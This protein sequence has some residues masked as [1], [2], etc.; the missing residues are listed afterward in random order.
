MDQQMAAPPVRDVSGFLVSFKERYEADRLDEDD[1]NTAVSLVEY[2]AQKYFN[3]SSSVMSDEEFDWLKEVVEFML[4]GE[5]DQYGAEVPE[6]AVAVPHEFAEMLG[7][8]E[9]KNDHE[10]L[11]SWLKSRAASLKVKRLRVGVSEKDDGNSGAAV[12]E[13]GM[14]E[15]AFT[16]GRGGHGV[17]ITSALAGRVEAPED[18]ELGVVGRYAVQFEFMLTHSGLERMCEEIGK[19]MVSPRSAITG[20]L[21]QSDRHGDAQLRRKYIVP[22]ALGVRVHGARISREK[23]IEYIGRYFNVGRP[24]TDPQFVFCEFEGTPED[25]ADQIMDSVYFPVAEARVDLDYM[26]DGLVV[27][28]LGDKAREDLGWTWSGGVP[29][30]PNYALALKFPHLEK[31]TIVTRLFLSHEGNRPTPMCEYEPVF[32]NGHEMKKTS[33]ANWLRYDSLRLGIGSR[34]SV[35]LRNDVLCYVSRLDVPENELV[36]PFR[37]KEECPSCHS[38]LRFSKNRDDERVFAYC[39][40]AE[41][42]GTIV[43]RIVNWLSKLDAKGVK[44]STVEK[45]RSEGLVSSIQDLYRLDLK[46]VSSIPGLGEKSAKAIKDA[47]D[48]TRKVKDFQLLGSLGIEYVGRTVARELLLRMSLRDVLD[49]H[50][51]PSFVEAVRAIPGFEAARALQVREGVKANLSTINEL[52]GILK[53]SS[54]R[55]EMAASQGPGTK[56]KV[57]VTG[58]L[59]R[60]VRSKLKDQIESMGHKMTEGVAGAEYLVTNEDSASEKRVKADALGIPIITEDELYEMLG[61]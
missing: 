11:L 33:L 50:M 35:Q 49:T 39:T 29:K 59:F 31:E 25:I 12:F 7:G 9:K 26:I 10:G 19:D 60:Q 45:L 46:R 13:D 23:E 58:K 40:S 61:I 34:I 36:P 2:A 24:D 21:G 41:C 38:A 6:G 5:A 47:V 56:Y 18:V 48:S 32:F 52:L 54:V 51:Q 16:R 42:P 57:C 27:E 3:T 43:W 17:D 22:V 55:D 8:L 4:Q 20:I 1:V 15:R 14:L 44:R 28:I 30:R 53:V 37:L